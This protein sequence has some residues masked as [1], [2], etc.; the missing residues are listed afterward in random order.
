MKKFKNYRK[1]PALV[2][3]SEENLWEWPIILTK[4][5]SAQLWSLMIEEGGGR[6]QHLWGEFCAAEAGSGGGQTGNDRR[7][8]PS[9]RLLLLP[10]LQKVPDVL[11]GVGW[12]KGKRRVSERWFFIYSILPFKRS[13]CFLKV[14]FLF[15]G[16]LLF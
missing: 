9:R 16:C 2:S 1:C 11:V 14:V 7:R 13:P 6:G 8:R 3:W 4:T 15:K 10:V 5:P 12:K